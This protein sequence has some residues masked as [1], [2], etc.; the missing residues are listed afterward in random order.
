M[1]QDAGDG[2][3]FVGLSAAP[4]RVNRRRRDE[5]SDRGD[6]RPRARLNVRDSDLLSCPRDDDAFYCTAGRSEKSFSNRLAEVDSD[7]ARR[8]L[9]DSRT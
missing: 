1:A 6:G 9:N 8:L 2:C 7:R 4:G 5:K 3:R